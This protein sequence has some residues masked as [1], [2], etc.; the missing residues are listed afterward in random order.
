[1]PTYPRPKKVLAIQFKQIGDSVLVVPSLRA[2]RRQWPEC[3]L[4]VVVFENIAEILR[5]IPWINHVWGISKSKSPLSIF[6]T[7]RILF[8]LRNMKFCRSVDFGVNDR[9]AWFGFFINAKLRLGAKKKKKT[10]AFHIS[11][12]GYNQTIVQKYDD[13][14]QAS[15]LIS[16]LRAWGILP[17]EMKLELHVGNESPMQKGLELPDEFICL[18]LTTARSV[19]NWPVSKWSR[20]HD[21]LCERKIPVVVSAG[22]SREER[23]IAKSFSDASP[24]AM[25]LP[26]F[27]TIHAFLHF[28]QH[29]RLLVCGDTAP[30]HMAASLGVSTLTLFG[31]TDDELW[32]PRGRRHFDINAHCRC[33]TEKTFDPCK[34][35]SICM[36]SISAVEVFDMAIEILKEPEF[37]MS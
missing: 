15:V 2:I 16:V 13:Y 31:P 21:L 9:G 30:V 20:L 3:Q 36:D 29:S 34:M 10:G 4:H 32:K 25:V 8:K 19:K 17:N 5:P 12:Y 23:Q 7:F 33:K 11:N 14:Y 27:E 22:S 35:Q 1:M 6:R 26:T 24:N 18:H 28:I 37:S